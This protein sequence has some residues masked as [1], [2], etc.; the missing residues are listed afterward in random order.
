MEH[1]PCR[2]VRDGNW[3]YVRNLHPEYAFTTHI[4]LPGNLGQRRYFASWEDAARTNAQAAAIVNR[5]HARPAEE[6]YHL[7][8][9][10]HEQHKFWRGTRTGSGSSACAASSTDGCLTRA[11]RGRIHAP[12]RLLSD[13]PVT[14]QTRLGRRRRRTPPKTAQKRRLR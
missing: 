4:D 2:A 14:G 7:E 5:Y 3:K 9:D 8:S 10:P 11:I 1:Y 12:P 13:P 6:L